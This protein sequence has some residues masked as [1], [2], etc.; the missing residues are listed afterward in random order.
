LRDLA[1]PT[2][3]GDDYYKY[4]G[5][6]T[7]WDSI[8]YD[9]DLNQLYVGTGNG[10]PWSRRV[11]SMGKGDNLFLSSILALDPDT[12]RYIWHYQQTPGET[13]DFTATQQ[14]VLTSMPVDGT[15]RK[16]IL[17]APKNG[18]F[19]VIDRTN[20]R[21]LSAE[22]FVGVNWAERIDLKTGRPVENPEARF[23]EKP[24]LSYSGAAGAHN[25][26][27]MAYS[28]RTSWV[29]IPTQQIPF[30]YAQDEKFKYQPG[31]WNL[32]VDMMG[33]RLPTDEEGRKAMRNALQGWLMAWDPVAQR[34]VW[35]VTYDRPWNGGVLATASD[36]VFQGTATGHFRAYSALDGRQLWDFDVQSAILGGPV[37]YS[38][39]GEQ[40]VLVMVGNGGGLPLTLPD[41][42]GPRPRPPGRVMAFK[43][44]GKASLPP[45]PPVPEVVVVSSEDW[46]Q[47]IV[48]QGRVTFAVHCA[49]CHGM[50]TLSAGVLPDLRRS[51]ILT[52]RQ[53]WQGVIRGGALV[54]RGMVSFAELISDEEAE[55][56]RAYVASEAKRVAGGR[57][58]DDSNP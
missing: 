18:F 44:G 10:S 43:I 16:V 7:V 56:I 42:D 30:V 28:P 5:G 22:K 15:E 6:G 32:G 24:F 13:W 49:A 9:P 31:Q 53:A 12:G 19:Y 50:E 34:E 2:W 58:A 37:T 41:F 39:G 17:H 29:Y 11:R 8:V 48:E 4:G 57:R 21:V 25:W 20:G 54:S 55:A 26:F 1:R 51:N 38:V 35:R 52:D 46:T 27:P 47:E 40:F 23:E 33:A 14:M 3:F 36:L 45:L